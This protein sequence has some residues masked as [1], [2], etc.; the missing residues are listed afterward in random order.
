MDGGP[1]QRRTPSNPVSGVTRE[2]ESLQT[3]GDRTD[4]TRT[5]PVAAQGA[6][7]Q[8]PLAARERELA[9]KEL[10]ANGPV[11]LDIN[12]RPPPSPSTQTSMSL[13][14]SPIVSSPGITKRLPL[15]AQVRQ[16]VTINDGKPAGNSAKIEASTV[17]V[18]TE[19]DLSLSEDTDLTYDNFSMLHS[20]NEEATNAV[21]V[22]TAPPNK[23]SVNLHAQTKEIVTNGSHDDLENTAFET[24]RLNSL[25]EETVPKELIDSGYSTEKASPEKIAPPV[26]A[27]SLAVEAD[28]SIQISSRYLSR[29]SN[30]DNESG[31]GSS[32]DTSRNSNDMYD[33]KENPLNQK[34]VNPVDLEGVQES[35]IIVKENIVKSEASMNSSAITR[36]D[37]TTE[38]KKIV[39]NNT[40]SEVRREQ[41]NESATELK[42]VD[43]SDN[44]NENEQSE[45]RM[46]QNDVAIASELKKPAVCDDNSDKGKGRDLEETDVVESEGCRRSE[47][48]GQDAGK[49]TTF[50]Q[51][52]MYCGLMA[53][54]AI[55]SHVRTA[56]F[57]WYLY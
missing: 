51:V 34:E 30:S 47:P 1:G 11:T 48:D 57:P 23:T 32:T 10:K 39:S 26:Q 3:D 46:G 41:K 24:L 36:D 25:Q 38:L 5:N 31:I 20:R 52:F 35:E 27:D 13:V 44:N 22:D 55:F 17:N 19:Q 14:A 42:R 56:M 16:D 18:R 54:S 53:H 40:E 33:L 12:T 37:S 28:M 29:Y 15:P 45:L 9:T 2:T 6:A 7:A 8:K 49:L 43:V 4:S 21:T 50:L